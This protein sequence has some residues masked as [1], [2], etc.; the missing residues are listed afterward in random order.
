[1]AN[2]YEEMLTAVSTD[3]LTRDEVVAMLADREE[4][5]RQNRSA[6]RRLRRA[7]L[8]EKAMIEDVNWRKKRGLEK[9]AF[10]ALANCEWLRRKQ[11]CVLTGPTGLGKTWLACALA[12]RA[13]LEGFTALYLRIPRI[14]GAINMARADGSYPRLMDTLARTNLI[15]FDDWGQALAEQ[16]RRD[17]REIV[18]DRHERGS[19][20]VTSQVPPDRWHEVI[21]DPT[22]ADAVIDRVLNRAHRFALTGPSMRDPRGPDKEKGLPEESAMM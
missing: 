17:L 19:L 11:H 2:A 9:S 4:I 15:I 5:D 21:G 16:E 8:R 20:I 13:C 7:K 22:I 10:M 3:N 1:M 14:F 18:E 6:D 12:H